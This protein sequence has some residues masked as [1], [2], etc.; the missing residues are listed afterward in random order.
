MGGYLLSDG[1]PVRFRQWYSS[2]MPNL[3]VTWLTEVTP[4][5]GLFWGFGT[6]ERGEKY[7]IDPSMTLGFIAMRKL[8]R[9]A[10]LSLSATTIL[11]GDLQE[12]TCTAD[13]GAIGGIQTVNCRLAA[14][15]MPPAAT[16][17]YLFD[18]SPPDRTTV[19][20]RYVLRF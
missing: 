16:L 14:T 3:S 13:Y 19:T 9:S 2:D 7:R 10:T 1:T 8:S 15:T 6:G 4:N 18:E 20:L 12:G 5:F 11:G 17:D